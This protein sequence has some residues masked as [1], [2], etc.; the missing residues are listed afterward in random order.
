MKRRQLR[1][2]E[3]LREVLAEAIQFELKDPRLAGLISVTK[4]TL[5]PD[6]NEAKVFISIFGQEKQK[7]L[8]MRA[9][10][11][12]RGML[13]QAL[14][15]QCRLR[16]IPKLKFTLDDTLEKTQAFNELLN[17]AMAGIEPDEPESSKDIEESE[18]CEVE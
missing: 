5:S 15:K 17:R 14:S 3:L 10:E 11:S 4:V 9:L 6:Y 13:Q 7:P 2:G 1:L 12:S 18:D 16:V 8:A